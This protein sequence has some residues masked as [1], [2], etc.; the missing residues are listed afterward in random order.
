[1]T[2][3]IVPI[4]P[5]P[6]PTHPSLAPAA[7]QSL[8]QQQYLALTGANADMAVAVFP[9]EGVREQAQALQREEEDS[10]TSRSSWPFSRHNPQPP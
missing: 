10:G 2:C 8:G 7:Q 6:S 3:A 5:P 9:V 1:M 4:W